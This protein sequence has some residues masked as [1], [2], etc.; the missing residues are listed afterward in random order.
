MDLPEVFNDWSWSQDS[1]SK[2][3]H[4]AG[5]YLEQPRKPN[6][7]SIKASHPYCSGGVSLPMICRSL[8]MDW[9]FFEAED[10]QWILIEKGEYIGTSPIDGLKYLVQQ[11]ESD[12]EKRWVYISPLNIEITK[13]S[14]LVIHN[15]N[16]ASFESIETENDLWVFK[17]GLGR[18]TFSDMGKH[19]V[20]V[21]TMLK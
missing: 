5:Y 8:K 20:V 15:Q 9:T 18:L 7:E 19:V 1:I 11:E 13:Q 3:N 16:I 12:T 4:V 14:L 2:L 10:G 6:W 21:H 17:D